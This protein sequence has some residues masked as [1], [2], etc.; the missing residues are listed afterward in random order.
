M[1]LEGEA[2]SP[3]TVRFQEASVSPFPSFGFTSTVGF[4]EAWVSPFLF[5]L[6][7]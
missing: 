7:P 2:V 1:G 4:Q 6:T 3:S 5:R